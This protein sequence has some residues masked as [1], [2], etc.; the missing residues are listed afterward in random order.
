[1]EVL[2]KHGF[3]PCGL[4]LKDIA[5]WLSVG[6]LELDCLDLTQFCHLLLMRLTSLSLLTGNMKFLVVKDPEAFLGG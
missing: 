3:K 4:S 2:P 6:I 1:M 5:C